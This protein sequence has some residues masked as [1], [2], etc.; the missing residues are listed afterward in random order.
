MD[1]AVDHSENVFIHREECWEK[2]VQDSANVVEALRF[3]H[4][5]FYGSQLS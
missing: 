2:I 4:K 1:L 3:C 5:A